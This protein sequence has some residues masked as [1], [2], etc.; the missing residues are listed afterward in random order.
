[1][2]PTRTVINSLRTVFT[3]PPACLTAIGN[4]QCFEGRPCFMGW[5][6]CGQMSSPIVD[7]LF[8]NIVLP[9]ADTIANRQGSKCALDTEYDTLVPASTCWPPKA[10]DVAEPVRPFNAWGVYS[11]GFECPHG[12]TTACSATQGGSAGPNN[13]VPAFPLAAQE[14]MYGCCPS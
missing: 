7:F 12:Y 13:W 1:M 10:T 8:A 9:P 6:V 14:T 5:G 2:E 3:P 11:P 4:G